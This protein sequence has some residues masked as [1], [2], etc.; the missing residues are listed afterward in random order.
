MAL[1]SATAGLH[2]GDTVVRRSAGNM[3]SVGEDRTPSACETQDNTR[4]KGWRRS[5]VY[6][7]PP[8]LDARRPQSAPPVGVHCSGAGQ[9]FSAGEK[10]GN[11]QIRHDEGNT[12]LPSLRRAERARTPVSVQRPAL[13]RWPARCAMRTCGSKPRHGRRFLRQDNF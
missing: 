6:A 5:V 1:T 7:R 9:C 11:E 3:H 4:E 10:Q 8:R 2:S 13:G 12:L